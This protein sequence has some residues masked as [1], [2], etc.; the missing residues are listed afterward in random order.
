MRERIRIISYCDKQEIK[1]TLVSTP[2]TSFLNVDRENYDIYVQYIESLIEG[3]NVEYWDFNL[4][5]E[6]YFPDTSTYFRDDNHMNKYGAELF[7]GILAKLISGEIS[8]Q[9]L[10]YDSMEEKFEH[11]SKQPAIYG[12]SYEWEEQNGENVRNCRIVSNGQMEYQI[13]ITLEDGTTYYMQEFDD[14]D[15]FVLPEG[16]SGVCT[17]NYRAE[18]SGENVYTTSINF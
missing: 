8:Q 10:F 11:L 1:L 6:V 16:L 9:E 12:I 4:I 2:V 7:T 17:I 15:V 3:T 5:K 18:Q 14:N 13:A